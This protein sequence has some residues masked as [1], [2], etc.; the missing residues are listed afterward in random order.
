MK[1][2]I[3]D[4]IKFNRAYGDYSSGQDIEKVVAIDKSINGFETYEVS[5]GSFVLES[6]L[7]IDSIFLESEVEVG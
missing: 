3:G 4:Y 5:G 7:D 6:E 2:K 1:A